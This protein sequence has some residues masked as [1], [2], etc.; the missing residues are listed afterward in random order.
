MTE[1]EIREGYRLLGLCIDDEPEQ[2]MQNTAM[3]DRY[4]NFSAYKP[5]PTIFSDTTAKT[6]Y[7]F[8]RH[9]RKGHC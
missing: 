1:K 6:P 4:R 9:C 7:V 2:V 5:S 8:H 3:F